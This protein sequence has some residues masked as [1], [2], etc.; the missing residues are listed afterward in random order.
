[1]ET[2]IPDFACPLKRTLAQNCIYY[3]SL[4]ISLCIA[5]IRKCAGVWKHYVFRNILPQLSV[6]QRANSNALL[7][8][9][10]TAIIAIGVFGLDITILLR[11]LHSF[12][13][14]AGLR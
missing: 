10:L 11:E 8:P 6:K 7:I 5:L 3:P 14:F 12:A 2:A 4:E 13:N 9:S 1:M